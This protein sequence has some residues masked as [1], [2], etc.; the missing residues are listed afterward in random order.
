MV[1]HALP[2]A[3]LAMAMRPFARE[4]VLL[5]RGLMQAQAPALR[6]GLRYTI[7]SYRWP[8][9]P[10]HHRR[11]D[12]FCRPSYPICG[13]ASGNDHYPLFAAVRPVLA[14]GSLL[15]L[16]DAAARIGHRA[17]AIAGRRVDRS[18]WRAGLLSLAFEAVA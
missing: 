5:A 17:A 10:G 8:R 16:A 14:G 1:G 3:A 15:L 12:R 9:P 2:G 6:V 11:S 13:L 4:P 7:C 18:D